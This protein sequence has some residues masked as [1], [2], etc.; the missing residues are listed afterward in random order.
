MQV[1]RR[2][3]AGARYDEGGLQLT[4]NLC[5]DSPVDD[6]GV[7][8]AFTHYLDGSGRTLKAPFSQ[9]G[10]NVGPEY[11][12]GFNDTLG[13]AFPGESYHVS[14]NAPFATQGAAAAVFG[15]V[16]LHLEGDLA[17]GSS[18]W[19]SFEGKVSALNDIY[20]FNPASHRSFIG[21]LSTW[22]GRQFNGTP[23]EI[24]FVGYRPVYVNG[25]LS[26]FPAGGQ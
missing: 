15:H 2:E 8:D 21:E 23:Y 24:Q 6:L 5:Q 9:L 14:A 10:A 7:G 4:C 19:W 11:F 20:D 16:T 13:G 1:V 12:G 17:V 22:V 25:Q 18:G 26:W 3:F